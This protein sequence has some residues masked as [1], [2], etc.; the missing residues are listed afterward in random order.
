MFDG[1]VDHHDLSFS[2]TNTVSTPNV[3]EPET[4]ALMLAELGVV[5]F[6]ARRRKI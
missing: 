3:P 5:G 6:V 2:F 4:D 1:P